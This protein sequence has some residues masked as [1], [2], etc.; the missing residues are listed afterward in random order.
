MSLKFSLLFYR[1]KLL[2]GKVVHSIDAMAVKIVTSVGC[3]I[4]EGKAKN[5]H[6]CSNTFGKKLLM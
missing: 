5:V 4:L 2:P 1:K 6:I 3:E